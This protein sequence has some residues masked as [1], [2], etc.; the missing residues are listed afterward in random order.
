[1]P[2]LRDKTWTTTTPANVEDAQFWEDHLISDVDSTKLRNMEGVPSG[3]TAGQVLTRTTSTSAPI[4]WAD[5]ASSG[6][7]IQDA[8]GNAMPYQEILQFEGADVSND[9]TNGKTVVDCH[10][11]KGDAATIQV[12]T[13]TTLPSGSPATV[14]NS[15][16]SSAAVFDFGIP[17]GADGGSTIKITTAET[18][19]HGKNITLTGSTTL[20]ATFDNNGVATFTGVIMTGTLTLYTSDGT[21]SATKAIS[22][23]YFGNYEETISFWSAI[24]NVT[25]TGINGVTVYAK[26]NGVTAASATVT[27]GSASLT[28]NSTGTYSIELTVNPGADDEYTYSE[29]VAVSAESTYSVSLPIFICTLSIS[30]T[31]TE[32]YSQ[33]I[34]VTKGGSTVGTTAFS[35]QGTATFRVHET[36]TYTL[37]CTYG[38][39]DYSES[40]TIVAGDDGQTKPVS[41]EMLITYSINVTLW[42]AASDTVTFTDDN[43]Q[44]IVVTAGQNDSGGLAP[45][46]KDNVSITITQPSIGVDPTIT[47]TSSVAKDLV[48]GNVSTAYAKDITIHGNETEIFILPD[49][50]VYWY[51]YAVG[52]I[53]ANS[54]NSGVDGGQSSGTPTLAINNPDITITTSGG[55]TY[56]TKGSV[57]IKK[58]LDLSNYTKIKSYYKPE[59]SNY[60]SPAIIASAFQQTY[61]TQTSSSPTITLGSFAT[62]QRTINTGVTSGYV[63]FLCAWTSSAHPKWTVNAIWLE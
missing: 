21:S 4:E 31:S 47:F 44:Q 20:T 30:T 27:N 24:I 48:G 29:S 63:A 33:T 11:Q 15:G 34:T 62:Y 7:T 5:P 26:K 42:S 59:N 10:G 37:T 49:S 6:H 32:L 9:A 55:G 39:E 58:E 60:A 40:I 36:G 46:E 13:V 14:T 50:A 19:L 38:G 53:I 41:I 61:N 56:A 35:A 2:N 3:G 17:S 25:A 45:G 12:G 22:V 23:P 1:M 16:T 51:G 8:N 43:G 52:D 57:W 28:V 54:Y 18:T